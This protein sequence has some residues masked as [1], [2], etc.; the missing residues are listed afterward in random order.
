MLSKYSCISSIAFLCH[1]AFDVSLSLGTFNNNHDMWGIYCRLS[2]PKLSMRRLTTSC[3]GKPL[4][5]ET[6][7]V[8]RTWEYSLTVWSGIAW[9]FIVIEDFDV[10]AVFGGTSNWWFINC[11]TSGEISFGGGAQSLTG[12]LTGFLAIL[13]DSS[14]PRNLWNRCQEHFSSTLSMPVG[15]DTH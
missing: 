7:W 12:K 3:K 11:D 1:S 13:L 8:L 15:M 4:T 2:L 14:L 6:E 9:L 10:I 5:W